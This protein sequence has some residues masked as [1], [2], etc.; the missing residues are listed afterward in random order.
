MQ[1]IHFCIPD[2]QLLCPFIDESLA[3]IASYYA[4]KDCSLEHPPPQPSSLTIPCTKL[5][6]E[7][8]VAKHVRAFKDARSSSLL[9]RDK[10]MRR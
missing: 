6:L 8:Y 10:M 2:A 3:V 9:L 1:D 5:L 7:E 4:D